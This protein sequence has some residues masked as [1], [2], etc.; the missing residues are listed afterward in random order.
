[1]RTVLRVSTTC[2]LFEESRRAAISASAL[3]PVH[4]AP[5]A[6]VPGTCLQQIAGPRGLSGTHYM[7]HN[8][9][10]LTEIATIGGLAGVIISVI[11]LA[12]Q[13]RS[14]AQQTKISNAIARAS[15]ISNE[16]S[17]LRQ[18]ISLFIEYPDLRQYFYGSRRLPVNRRQRARII[19]IAE[20]LGDILEDGLVMDKILPTVRFS[21]RW[22]PYCAGFLSPA[23]L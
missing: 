3:L 10:M 19:S 20:V 14:V 23:L 2:H 12:W 18:V 6:H 15:V 17:S 4:V 11:L 7:R 9:K 13:T 5:G 8:V 22:P 16:S 21:E 1:M